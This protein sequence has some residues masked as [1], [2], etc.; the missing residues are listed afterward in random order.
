MTPFKAEE[1][2]RV[3]V[4]KRKA[5]YCKLCGRAADRL[6]VIAGLTVNATLCAECLTTGTVVL[7]THEPTDRNP[8]HA[9]WHKHN[10]ELRKKYGR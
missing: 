6:L 1:F 9:V 7:E 4:R 10:E 2:M 5:Q 3:S 8:Q